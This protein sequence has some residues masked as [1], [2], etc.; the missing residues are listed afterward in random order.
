MSDQNQFD[1]Y[2]KKLLQYWSAFAAACA[3]LW[4]KAKAGAGKAASSLRQYGKQLAQKLA[5]FALKVRA[6]FQ[7]A[8]ESLRRN[9]KK[10][11]QKITAFAGNVREKLPGGKPAESNV[12][13]A[14]SEAAEQPQVEEPGQPVQAETAVQIAEEPQAEPAAPKDDRTLI[15]RAKPYVLEVGAFFGVIGMAVKFIVKWIWKLRKVIM[16]APV[17]WA[18]VK[19]AMENMDRLP[20][21]VGLDIQS[22]GEFARMIT[23]EEAVYW[24]LGITLFC[25]LLMFCSKKPILPW[26]ISIFTLVLPWLIWLTNYY[27]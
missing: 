7:K 4:G 2:K 16:A 21:K 17:V 12:Q 13:P 27:A 1:E 9:F 23:R 22:T 26:V 15:Q 25:L 19:L 5:A 8:T 3:A 24:P 20:E 6:W 10:L 14:K 11:G 18:A